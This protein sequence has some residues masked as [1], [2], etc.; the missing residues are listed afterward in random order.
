MAATSYNEHLETAKATR[1]VCGGYHALRPP[2]RVTVAE[3]A[4]E[5]LEII[6]RGDRRSSKVVSR[7][8][9]QIDLPEG[10]QIGAIVRGDE[11]IMAHHD[12]VIQTDDHVIVF[13]PSKRQ[14]RAVE[15]LFQVGA[16]FF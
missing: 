14:V 2:K 4:A 9:E 11:V 6:A 1:D 12:T 16:T 10:V 3:G 8:I 15:K 7:R 13:L 5:S